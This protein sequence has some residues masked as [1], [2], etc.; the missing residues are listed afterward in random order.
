MNILEQHISR[1][2]LPNEEILAWI[3]WDPSVDFDRVV[4]RREAD[5]EFT[6]ILNVD[7][8]ELESKSVEGKVV[9]DRDRLQIPGF[10]GFTS[11]YRPVPESERQICFEVEFVKNEKQL[12]TV[13]LKTS[14]IRPVIAI[15]V[16]RG[17][18]VSGVVLQV[19][20]AKFRLMNKG[21]SRATDLAPFIKFADTEAMT[22]TIEHSKEKVPYDPDTPF[23]P[24]SEQM[25]PKF[26]LIGSGNAMLELGF[27]FKDSIGN[28][29]TTEIV[30]IPVTKSEKRKVK[31]PIESML[32][33]QSAMVLAPKRY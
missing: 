1:W 25:V 16:E 2:A 19:Q 7:V 23:V 33:G 5:I 31:V 20:P 15:K 26:T 11:A 14:V 13:S 22:V 29:Y 24:A 28:D 30:R 21:N 32:S 17:I 6:R 10:V 3:K 4:I 9:I 18:D 12:E 8:S 27:K